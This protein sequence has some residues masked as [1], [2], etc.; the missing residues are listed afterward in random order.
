[1]KPGSILVVDDDYINR[2]LLSV[3]LR[4]RGHTVSTADNGRQA[5]ALLMARRFDAILLDIMMPEMNGYQVLERMKADKDLAH[6]PVI[7]I[8]AMGEVADVARCIEMGADDY[9]TK[10]FDPVLLHARISACLEKKWLH[11]EE[12]ALMRR[13]ETHR[14]RAEDL[15]QVVIPLGVAMSA[16]RDFNRLLEMILVNAKLICNADGGSLY[17]RTPDDALRFEIMR[18]DSLGVALGG[19]TGKPIPFKPLRLF[20]DG[21]EPNHHNIATHAALTARS[22]NIPDAYDAKG[23]DFSG[24]RAFDTANHYRSKSFLSIPLKNHL[25]HVI[26]VLQLINAI[27]SETG[28]VIP[29]DPNVQRIVES[30]SALA[31]VALEAYIREQDLKEQIHQLQIVIDETK[32]ASQ[33]AEI[34]ETEYFQALRRKAQQLRSRAKE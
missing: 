30:L 27:D 19:T 25:N 18:T 7:V 14:K 32:K 29:F 21:G 3:V 4:G 1:M 15:L 5:L 33:V 26:G 9:L 2:E 8:S 6:I 24:T 17:L 34:T 12:Q 16:E 28:D 31:T 11:D 22:V 10:P 23:F 20:K 13:V